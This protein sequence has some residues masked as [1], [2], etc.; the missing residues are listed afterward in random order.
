M[1]QLYFR[2]TNQLLV[3][4]SSVFVKFLLDVYTHEHTISTTTHKT[5]CSGIINALVWGKSHTEVAT[6][7]CISFIISI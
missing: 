4:V 5:G 7:F 6:F 1:M 3:P 2:E